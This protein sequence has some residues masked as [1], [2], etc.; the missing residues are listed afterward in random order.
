MKAEVSLL[1]RWVLQLSSQQIMAGLSAGCKNNPKGLLP[2]TLFCG[3]VYSGTNVDEHR[4]V[5]LHGDY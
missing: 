4:A 2:K 1:Y 5:V 3:I